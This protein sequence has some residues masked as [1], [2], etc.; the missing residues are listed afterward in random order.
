MDN[1]KA[2]SL[3]VLGTGI[4]IF[5]GTTAYI[6][7]TTFRKAINSLIPKKKVKCGASFLFIGDSNTKADFSYA[8]QLLNFCSNAKIKKIA[9]NGKNTQWMYEQL[10]AEF[11]NG[12]KYDV[13]AIL[14]GSNDISGGMPLERTKENLNAMYEIARW[15]GAIVVAIAPPNKDFYEPYTQSQRYKLLELVEWLSKNPN[16][17]YFINWHKITSRKDY[18]LSDNLHPNKIAHHILLNEL[19]KKIIA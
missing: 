2:I 7:S 11:K 18:F 3:A 10:M 19:I 15:M 4:A 6:F 16:T 17:D 5:A 9:E 13:V 12:K 8:D 1:K 14:A